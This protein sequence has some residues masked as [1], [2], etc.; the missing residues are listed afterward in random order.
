[1]GFD[2]LAAM[3]LVG[4]EIGRRKEPDESCNW[5]TG[6][7]HLFEKQTEK[8]NSFRPRV[9]RFESTLRVVEICEMRQQNKQCRRVNGRLW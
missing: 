1:M 4:D 2:Y 3:L 5:T 7:I 9:M 8:F 6:K